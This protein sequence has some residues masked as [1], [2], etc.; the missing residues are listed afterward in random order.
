MAWREL[1]N[2]ELIRLRLLLIVMLAALGLLA[3]NLWRMQVARGALYQHNLGEQS[4]RRVRTA[5]ARGRILARDGALLAD[6]KPSYQV[7]LYL[8]ELRQPGRGWT[9]TLRKVETVLQDISRLLERP[10]H[11]TADD[12]QNHIRARLPLPLVAWRNIDE[13]ARARLAER[14]STWRG[15][16]VVAVPLR[17]YPAGTLAAHVLGYVSRANPPPDDETA[18]RYYEPDVAGKEGIERRYDDELRGQ[19]GEKVVIVDVSGFRYRQHLPAILERFRPR[20]AVPGRDVILT[21]DTNVQARVEQALGTQPGAAVVVD[22][23]NGDVLAMASAPSFDPNEIAAGLPPELWQALVNDPRQPLLPRALAGQYAPGSTFKPVTALAALES[24]RSTPEVT[25]AC[26]GYFML[27]RARFN[28]WEN[29]AGHGAQNLHQ[30]LQHSCN[31]YFFNLGLR[32]GP[33]AIHAMAIQFGFGHQTGIDLG[34]EMSGLVPDDAWKRRVQHDGWR[35]GDTCNMAIG[36]GALLVTPLQMAMFAAALANGGSVFQPRLVA[37]VRDPVSGVTR[38]VPP[39]LLHTLAVDP[40]RLRVVREGLRAVVNTS[41]GSGK[42]AALDNIVVAGKTGTAEHGAKGAGQKWT[43]MIA[44]V[45]YERPRYA[46]AMLVE[47]GV[48]GGST[49]APL[50][51]DVLYDLLAK[52]ALLQ[53]EG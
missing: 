32:C 31:V 30:A 11:L 47:E 29:L 23:A 14:A 42:K 51:H 15:V 9:R 38:T 12:I 53:G 21:L 41:T 48:S 26:P 19:A 36:Q 27:G 7:V 46:L 17:T 35:D 45:P 1:W 39:R 3:V 13:T 44:F 50:V 4:I 2:D 49:V 37:G 6:N 43:W 52:P 16:D 33:E 20:E 28:C 5:G 10:S 34:R 25:Y 22:P 18:A 24:G 40:A 8:E